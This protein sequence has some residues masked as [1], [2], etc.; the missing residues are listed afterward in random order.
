MY[1][2]LTRLTLI[3]PT[4]ER[5]D[6]AQRAIDYWG[7]KGPHLIV[8]D[9]SLE[10]ISSEKLDFS[11]THIKY[12]HRPVGW[13]QRFLEVLD[14][15]ETEFVAIAGDDEFYIPS[16]VEKCINELDRDSR[17]VACSGRAIGFTLENQRILGS[18][19]YPR[20]K[21]YA[22]D[23]DCAEGR[24]LQ[25]MSNYVPSLIYAVCRTSQWKTSWQN[26]VQKEFSFFASGEL[27][28]EMYLAYAGRSKVIPE[29]LWLRSHGETEPVR[30]T[31]PWLDLKNRIPDW[32]E[33]SSKVKEHEEFISIM[34]RGFNEL[35]PAEGGDLRGAVVAGVEAYLGFYEN[36][37]RGRIG[38]KILRRG[39]VKMIPDFV[40]P[41]LKNMLGRF[42]RHKSDQHAEL[43]QA[44]RVL[45][46]S[47]VRV[48]FQALEEIQKTIIQFH[49]NRNSLGF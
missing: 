47:G 13:Y 20:L 26:T 44:A 39:A 8:L 43:L 45:E 48:D 6:F 41:F 38:S 4:Y 18:P 21:D 49:K 2:S 7:D 9:G 17:L 22:I 33:D 40:K 15:I 23:A 30:G 34:S 27:Q 42:L 32:W 35:L 24:V 5:Q 28:I 16:A 19:Q 3:I 37:K 1:Q 11:G 25:H 31:E 12:I 10:A 29:L 46:E 36:R 14:L